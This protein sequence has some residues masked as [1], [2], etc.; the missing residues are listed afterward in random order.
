[1]GR[2]SGRPPSLG[3]LTGVSQ[4][5]PA[6]QQIRGLCGGSAVEGHQG[7]RHPGQASEL[8]PPLRAN[9]RDFNLIGASADIVL[10]AMNVHK[11]H[12]SRCLV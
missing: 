12:K 11:G 4:D 2:R 7:C 10:E 6:G 3:R 8:R 1:M 5:E 9:R